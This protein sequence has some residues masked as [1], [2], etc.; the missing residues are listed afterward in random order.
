MPADDIRECGRGSQGVRVA[1]VDE[2]D[3]VVSAAVINS[4][5]AGEEAQAA[6]E[7]AK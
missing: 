3:E 2:G 6:P 1:R 4:A 5:A 7:A